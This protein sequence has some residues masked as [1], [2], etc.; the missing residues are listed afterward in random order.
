MGTRARW[1]ARSESAA[2]PSWRA[3]VRRC[4]GCGRK[5]YKSEMHAPGKKRTRADGRVDLLILASHIALG[6]ALWLCITRNS[7][8]HGRLAPRALTKDGYARPCGALRII[9]SILI[10]RTCVPPPAFWSLRISI[11][12]LLDAP[13]RRAPARIARPPV[14]KRQRQSQAPDRRSAHTGTAR[15]CFAC[16]PKHAQLLLQPGMEINRSRLPLLCC[17]SSDHQMRMHSSS[18][19]R[20]RSRSERA[21]DRA[22]MFYD[23]LA[24]Q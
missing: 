16:A 1:S 20:S 13:A 21:S 11:I 9:S 19:S 17:V 15:S 10:V 2:G 8:A 24:N 3:G 5:G 12:S 22:L 14:A 18:R 23:D 6:R 4:C 7:R